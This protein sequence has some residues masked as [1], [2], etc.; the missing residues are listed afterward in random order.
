MLPACKCF[1]VLKDGRIK[2]LEPGAWRPHW[3]SHRSEFWPPPAAHISCPSSL[4]CCSTTWADPIWSRNTIP[5]DKA[6]DQ[7]SLSGVMVNNISDA[8]AA[9]HP[10]H[11]HWSSVCYPRRRLEALQLYSE[12]IAGETGGQWNCLLS[13]IACKLFRVIAQN[14]KPEY[15]HNV[16]YKTRSRHT[17]GNMLKVV[18]D[19]FFYFLCRQRSQLIINI[20]MFSVVSWY[21]YHDRDLTN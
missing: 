15:E 8:V 20:S 12:I 1:H 7:R 10:Q 14:H 16:Y 6:L 18:W 5:M 9:C 19:F 21:I 11:E 4:S 13:I 3:Y 17:E 2:W